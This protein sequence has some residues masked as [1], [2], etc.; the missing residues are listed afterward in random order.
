MSRREPKKVGIKAPSGGLKQPGGGK[1]GAGGGRAGGK[2][3][4]AAKKEPQK[5]TEFEIPAFSIAPPKK[6]PV[7]DWEKLKKETARRQAPK[8]EDIKQIKRVLNEV[9]E[10]PNITVHEFINLVSPYTA[11]NGQCLRTIMAED[12]ETF[13]K[14]AR[15][16]YET[17]TQDV[18]DVLVNE[19]LQMVQFYQEK[20]DHLTGKMMRAINDIY[21]MVPEFDFEKYLADTTGYLNKVLPLPA[22]VVRDEAEVEMQRR[23]AAYHR[24]Q[25]L[26]S[27][28]ERMN[29]E[30]KRLQSRLDELKQEQQME[31]NRAAEMAAE[32]ETKRQ[33]LIEQEAQVKE[34]L[35]KLNE[36][37]EKSFVDNET[38]VTKAHNREAKQK[39]AG[40][41]AVKK[42]AQPPKKK[43]KPKRPEW[44]STT[45]ADIEEGAAQEA[46]DAEVTKA[47]PAATRTTARRPRRKSPHFSPIKTPPPRE[48]PREASSFRTTHKHAPRS[49]FHY[50]PPKS[51]TGAPP[52]ETKLEQTATTVQQKRPQPR[53]RQTMAP[54][55]TWGGFF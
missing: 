13:R 26:R 24:L 19:Q 39:P 38:N 35:D 43:R 46:V 15:K 18:S 32:A 31:Q 6:K 42:G 33:Q 12:L 50:S 52:M 17:M 8:G 51:P 10:S 37:V 7:I 14:L 28:G 53:V 34:K 36:S 11:D 44:S 55:D 47:A 29:E 23:Q 1:G 3:G 45:A 5:V 25:W 16:V 41:G 40:T 9:K 49:P 21:D 4:G 2:A 54:R 20:H 27:E 22:E 30:N 48:A